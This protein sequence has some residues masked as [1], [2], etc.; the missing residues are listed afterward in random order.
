MIRFTKIKGDKIAGS[1]VLVSNFAGRYDKDQ[2]PHVVED[3]NNILKTIADGD[4]TWLLEMKNNIFD[5]KG[6]SDEPTLLLQ[7]SVTPKGALR[8]SICQFYLAGTYKDLMTDTILHSF[9]DET[10]K[11]ENIIWFRWVHSQ[12]TIR[13][14]RKMREAIKEVF[15]IRHLIL[16]I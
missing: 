6:F 15:L 16:H 10:K 3:I 7:T 12:E 14:W 5:M 2:T 11:L 13:Q 1:M 8:K 4:D 9:L